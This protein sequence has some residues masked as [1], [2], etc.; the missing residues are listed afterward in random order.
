MAIDTNKWTVN[1]L[2][3]AKVRIYKEVTIDLISKGGSDASHFIRNSVVSK[4]SCVA[5]VFGFT[6]SSLRYLTTANY[7][8]F[9]CYIDDNN[10]IEFFRS[11]AGN[12]QLNF[13]IVAVGS[14]VYESADVDNDFGKFEIRV[15][16]AHAISAW[17]YNGI[18]WVQ[19]GATQTVELGEK[20]LFA[21]SLGGEVSKLSIGYCYI[22]T[23]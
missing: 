10:R 21:A 1:N 20:Y 12:K 9:G 2:D 6:A 13:R 19:I 7:H 5:G 23:W 4:K 15:T 14:T 11:G 17:K 18:N 22:K 16:A 3:P 8:A